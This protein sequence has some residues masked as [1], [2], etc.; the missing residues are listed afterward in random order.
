M[1][2]TAMP[3]C[4]VEEAVAVDVLHDR[5]LSAG[6]DERVRA[7]VGRRDVLRV[8]RDEI[9]GAWPGKRSLDVRGGHEVLAV[10]RARPP[11]F[12]LPPRPR[13]RVLEQHAARGE[14]VTDAVGGREVAPAARVLAG[15]DQA[16]DLRRRRRAA[17]RLPPGAG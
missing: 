16:L 8:A 9:G 6:H 5:A 13:R 11:P 10:A 4:A 7:R 2:F 15:V 17:A 3:G 14:V 12:P 1:A